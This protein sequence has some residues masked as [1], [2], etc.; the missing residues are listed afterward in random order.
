MP[1]LPEGLGII[2]IDHGSRR[3]EANALLDQV[4]PL[5]RE[6]TGVSIVE[7][8]HMELASPTLSD[9]FAACVEQG[10]TR[11]AIHPYFLAPGRHST[12]DIP[13]MAAEVA[14]TWPDVPYTVS[15]PLGL[16]ARMG[17]VIADRIREA[18]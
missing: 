14:T 3:D 2:L 13:A 17:E 15:E 7:V 9:A 10:A 11:I 6:S 16:D 8:A 12:E 18:L 1:T 5:V 4:V